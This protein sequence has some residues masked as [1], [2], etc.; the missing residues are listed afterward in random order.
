MKSEHFLYNSDSNVLYGALSIR[1]LERHDY[2]S[3]LKCQFLERENELVVLLKLLIF[4][5]KGFCSANPEVFQ[6][7]HVER[8]LLHDLREFTE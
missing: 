1:L 7:S 6:V 5:V 2:Y 4:K 3:T 8:P